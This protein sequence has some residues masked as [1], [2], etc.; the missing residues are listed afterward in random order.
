MNQPV[1]P[2]ELLRASSPPERA[3]LGVLDVGSNVIRL[4]VA[5]LFQDGSFVVVA[6]EREAVRLGEEVFRTGAL[7]SQAVE[8]WP[9][10]CGLRCWPAATA[11]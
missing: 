6:D 4:Q 3:S 5:R 1:P 7:S 2:Q 10:W 8:R 11:S 9:R